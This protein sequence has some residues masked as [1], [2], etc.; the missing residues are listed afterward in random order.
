MGGAGGKRGICSKY[1][2]WNSQRINKNKRVFRTYG[3]FSLMLWMLDL[4]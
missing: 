1:T 2:V 4:M 3:T